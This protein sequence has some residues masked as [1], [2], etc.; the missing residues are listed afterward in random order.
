MFYVSIIVYYQYELG[1]LFIISISYVLF[2][3]VSDHSYHFVL[4]FW[5]N[6]LS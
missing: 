1:S 3:T 4:S 5:A 6:R 2:R